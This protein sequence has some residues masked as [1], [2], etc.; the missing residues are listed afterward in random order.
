TRYRFEGP[1]QGVG[2]RMTWESGD[3]QVGQGSQEIIDS[4]PDRRVEM[5]LEFGDKGNGTATFLLEP[6]GSATRVRWE[7]HTV[8][9][10]DVFGRYVGL[11]L[12]SMIG[13]AYDKGLKDLKSRV[14]Q[15]QEK[16]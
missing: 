11:M 6:E 4:V 5:Q 7:F 16:P 13:I 3:S 12:D 2:S 14:E 1:E 10:W 8:F 9:G 15:A